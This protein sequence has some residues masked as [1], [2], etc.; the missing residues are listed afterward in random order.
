MSNGQ[1]VSDVILVGGGIM[2]ATLGTFIKELQ[3]DWKIMAFERLDKMGQESTEAWNNAGTGHSAL[4]ELNYTP[5]KNGSV[6]VSKAIKINEQYQLSRQFWAYLLNTKQ[7]DSPEFIQELPH[8]S[9]V[10]GADTIKFLKKRF[11]ILSKNPLFGGMEYTEDPKVVAEWSPLM[12]EGRTDGK[13]MAATKIDY[14]TDVDFGKLTIIMFD[15][16]KKKGVDVR[17]KHHVSDVKRTRDGLWE[18]TANGQK[19]LSKFVFLGNGGGSILLLQKSGI[20]EGKTLGSFPVSGVFL[21]CD[22]PEIVAKH[23]AKVYGKA[24]IG[25]PPMSVP[26]LD[27]RVIDGRK[28]LM[29][30]PYAGFSTNFLKNGSYF[31]LL[32]SLKLHNFK[33]LMGAAVNQ[34]VLTKY[35]INQVMMSHS[36]RVAEIRDFVP[37]TKD[38]DWFAVKAGQRVQII[39]N[40]EKMLGDLVF[41]TEVIAAAD[42]SLASLLGASPGASVAV[43]VMIELM[44]KCWPSKFKSWEPKIKEMIPSF[45]EKL[46]KNPELLKKTYE[47]TNKAFGG[48]KAMPL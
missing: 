8:I 33:T 41:G 30:G 1:N 15:N 26:H 28:Y 39:K 13:P 37:T 32:K 45:G 36:Q 38:S 42:G 10:Q 14:G 20:P 11:D 9:W 16:L 12:M 17:M 24:P 23:E 34:M 7:I 44:Q 22:K 47:D 18:V 40:T 46:E 6:D 25:A 4:C 31:D 27:T 19:H 3:P 5:E 48:F 21:A 35:L 2:C 43:D 29:F